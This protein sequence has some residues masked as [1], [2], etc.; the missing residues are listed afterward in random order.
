VFNNFM[1]FLS[2]PSRAGK[3]V[4]LAASNRPDLLDAALVRS[5]RFDAKLPILPPAREDSKGRSQILQALMTKHKV[6][7]ATDLKPTLKDGSTGLGR[8][9]QDKEKIWTGAEIEVIMKEAISTAAY[10][11]RKTADEETDYTIHLDDWNYAMDVILP[12]TNEVEYQTMLALL[13]VDNLAYCPADWQALA[14]DK[15]EIRQRLSA[16]QQQAA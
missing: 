13:Y 12:N 14:R 6:A 11:G 15:D 9:L 7:F 4:V 1:T 2:D 8:L 5:G 16:G 10:A 3:I